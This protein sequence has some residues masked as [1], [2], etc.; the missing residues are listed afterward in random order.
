MRAEVVT[1][2]NMC[3]IYDDKGNVLVQDK[4]DE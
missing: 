1:L 3:M 4:V 2:T